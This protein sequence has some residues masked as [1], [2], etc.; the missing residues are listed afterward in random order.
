MI[1]RDKL[2]EAI[3][4]RDNSMETVSQLTTSY[5]NALGTN[6]GIYISDHAIVRYLERVKGVTFN[7]S[8]TDAAKLD[9]Y[10]QAPEEIREEMLTLEEDR[11]ILKKQLHFYRRPNTN[12]GYIIKNLTITTVLNFS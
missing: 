6:R 8:L 3:I 2:K 12:Y 4:V 5:I 11:F 7:N 10:W 9:N 1:A